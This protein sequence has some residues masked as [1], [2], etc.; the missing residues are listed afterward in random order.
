M[1]ERALRALTVPLSLNEAAGYQITSYRT[2]V[3]NTH[4][5]TRPLA[6]TRELGLCDTDKYC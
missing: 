6:V 4:T 3:L 1:L 2:L 5:E